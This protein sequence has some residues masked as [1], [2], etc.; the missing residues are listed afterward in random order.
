MGDPRERSMK[1]PTAPPLTKCSRENLSQRT[2]HNPLDRIRF[3]ICQ[4]DCQLHGGIPISYTIGVS[5]GYLNESEEIPSS[6]CKTTFNCV[7]KHNSH[8]SHN[9]DYNQ[10]I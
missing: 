6:L 7:Q 4:C 8:A 5:D 9:N 3:R 10:T 2:S 1:T